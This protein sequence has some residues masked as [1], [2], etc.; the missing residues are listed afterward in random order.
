MNALACPDR[1]ELADYLLGNLPEEAAVQLEEHLA[2]CPACE[3]TISDM[4]GVSDTLIAGLRRRPAQESVALLSDPAFLAVVERARA[5][6]PGE[7]IPAP[8]PPRR[9]GEYELL[10]KLGQ[11][12]MGEVYKARQTRLDKIVAL[13][14]LPKHRTADPHAQAR[15]EREMKAVGRLRH[16]NLIEAYDAREIDGTAI[17]VMEYIEGADLAQVC[18]KCGPLPVADACEVIRHTALGLQYAHEHGMVH[19]DIK[20]SNLMLTIE[21][22]VKIL[23][24]G[25]ALLQTPEAVS[26]AGGETTSSEQIMGTVDYMAP[27]QAADSHRVDIG[28][29]IYSLGCTLYTLLAGQAP[30]TGPAYVT[31]MKKLLAHAQAPVPPLARF[32]SDV[33]K[34]L[35]AI[36]DHM[37]AKLPEQRFSTPAD[38]AEALAPFA[39]GSDARR[40]AEFAKRIG[41]AEASGYTTTALAAT[42]PIATS[43]S[44]DTASQGRNSR[45]LSRWERVRVRAIIAVAL[46]LACVILLATIFKMRTPQGTLVVEVSDPDASVEVLS[47][48]GKIIIAP[49]SP[50]DG[51]V[52]ISLAP[53][54][55]RLRLLKEGVELYASEFSLVAG[56]KEYIKAKLEKPP[57]KAKPVVVGPPSKPVHLDLKPDPLPTFKPGQPLSD[58]ALVTNPAPMPGALSWTL[59]TI[60]H[61]GQVLCLAFSPDGRRLASVADD[62]MLRI[63]DPATGRLLRIM[64]GQAPEYPDPSL[65]WSPDGSMLAWGEKKGRASIWQSETG[66]LVRRDVFGKAY[67]GGSLAWS[68]DGRWLAAAAEDT[69]AVLNLSDGTYRPLPRGKATAV[70]WSP[71]GKSLACWAPSGD[72]PSSGDIRIFDSETC[73]LRMKME[74]KGY[75][76]SRLA[77]SPDGMTLGFA[78]A[79]RELWD[80]RTGRLRHRFVDPAGTIVFSRDS[81]FVIFGTRMYDA[82]SG[83]LRWD[84]EGVTGALDVSPDA[85]TVAGGTWDGKIVLR[86]A[87][88]RA[89]RTTIGGYTSLGGR[90][91]VFST[92]GHRLAITRGPTVAIWD[93]KAANTVGSYRATGK[94]NNTVWSRDGTRLVVD[95]EGVGRILDAA[96]WKLVQTLPEKCGLGLFDSAKVW[97]KGDGNLRKLVDLDTRKVHF[98]IQG[99][100]DGCA[101]S[102]DGKLV[103]IP[104]DTG[105]TIYDAS[106]GAVVRSLEDAKGRSEVRLAWS[107]D[108]KT[109][110]GKAPTGASG[111]NVVDC[112]DIA[113]GRY[114]PIKPDMQRLTGFKEIHALGWVDDKTLAA[115]NSRGACLWDP[116]LR[117]VVRGIPGQPR[118]EMRQPCFFSAGGRLV[119][120]VGECLVRLRSLDDGRLLYT[121]LSLRDDMGPARGEL[122]GVISP[123]GHVR[124]V[125]GLGEKLVYV[126]QTEKGQETLTPEEFSKRYGWKNDPAKVNGIK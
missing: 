50:V 73:K 114:T 11:G 43:A 4:D 32:R 75:H 23:D 28:A 9:L 126:V 106:T 82:D 37:L 26:G 29:D 83:A 91:A 7:S 36:L 122:T 96:T 123:E 59:E 117:V 70:A 48:E 60:G 108:G 88:T 52:T 2:G 94:V 85:Q 80:L 116:K 86:D 49:K 47:E 58:M 14:I 107:P 5:V 27:E 6:G 62:G 112:W 1:D 31:K 71:D 34:E 103:A 72:E 77:W 24:L 78:G 81:R 64:V 121:I 21:G 89:L 76:W 12:G 33:P 10:E 67:W 65:S 104:S 109:L 90:C 125:P 53:G 110:A 44:S 54:K 22:Q 66:R 35:I 113:S 105:A 40:L 15:F 61:R 18:R 51:K 55:G 120:F 3:Q 93:A 63:W 46:C 98:E 79:R 30:F 69:T 68:P 100:V 41:P 118:H 124:G 16:A 119:A 57:S 95:D 17:L 101:M 87:K 42:Q 56:G 19:R 74:S 102:P 13:K 20:P 92:S 38:V 97:L 39:A 84:I 25:L 111:E 45:P 8:G 99:K 115:G